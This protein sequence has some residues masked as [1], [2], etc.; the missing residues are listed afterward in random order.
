MNTGFHAPTG[1][2]QMHGALH[3]IAI[4]LH[5]VKP[6]KQNRTSNATENTGENTRENKGRAENIGSILFLNWDPERET[7]TP[8]RDPIPL[9]DP[10]TTPK[11]KD[12]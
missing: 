3:S 2:S 12:S 11:E 9:N 4:V 6:C 1:V 10:Y 8:K 5:H 7:E